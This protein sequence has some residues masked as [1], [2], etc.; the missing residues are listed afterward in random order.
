LPARVCG[1]LGVALAAFYLSSGRAQQLR[2]PVMQVMSLAGL[3]MVLLSIFAFTRSMPFPSLYA[4]LPVLGTVLI[5][6][7]GQSTTFVGAALG[8]R[9]FVGIGLISYSAY[10]WHQPLFAFA[11]QRLPGHPS[12]VMFL[13]LVVLTF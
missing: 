8:N 5:I 10:L 1:L 4:L 2:L 12:D 9:L 3:L 11:R 7:F 13:F 6:L